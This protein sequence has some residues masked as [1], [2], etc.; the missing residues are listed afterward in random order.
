MSHKFKFEELDPERIETIR[1]LLERGVERQFI[2]ER[3][4][5]SKVRLR[6]VVARIRAEGGRSHDPRRSNP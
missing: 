1:R 5:L 3:F 2:C 4:G 6:Q